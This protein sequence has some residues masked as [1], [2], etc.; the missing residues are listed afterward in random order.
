M[1][2]VIGPFVQGNAWRSDLEF[3]NHVPIAVAAGGSPNRICETLLIR[4][5]AAGFENKIRNAF[6]RSRVVAKER[7]DARPLR[8]DRLSF[9]AFPAL[10]NLAQGA[11]LLSHILLPQ[12]QH[13]PSIAEMLTKSLGLGD[14]P[15]L[16]DNE[17]FKRCRT[18]PN[19][20]KAK[21]QNRVTCFSNEADSKFLLRF[22]CIV[23]MNP[24]RGGLSGTD[25]EHE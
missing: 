24:C 1:R 3:R 10:I 25:Y 18:H 2:R 14:K 15:F 4:P 22:M 12:S 17:R 7:K 19:R 11:E 23:A 6:F 9:V 21:W 20:K 16:F 5:L 8:H 13:Q